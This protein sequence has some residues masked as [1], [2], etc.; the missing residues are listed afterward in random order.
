MVRQERTKEEK[1]CRSSEERSS[2]GTE[3]LGNKNRKGLL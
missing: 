3:N 1:N 2:E